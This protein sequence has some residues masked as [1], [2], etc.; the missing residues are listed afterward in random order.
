MHLILIQAL[1][2]ETELLSF[3]AF[4]LLHHPHSSSSKHVTQNFQHCISLVGFITLTYPAY[5]PIM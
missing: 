4:C 2:A 3:E 5:L 1:M